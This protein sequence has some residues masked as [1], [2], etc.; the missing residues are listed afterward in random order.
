MAVSGSAVS[1]SNGNFKKEIAGFHAAYKAWFENRMAGKVRL[2]KGEHVC[3][4]FAHV[5]DIIRKYKH[6]PNRANN[7][8]N[9]YVSF[10][11]L[12]SSQERAALLS[13]HLKKFNYWTTKEWP[14]KHSY[15]P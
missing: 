14:P 8:K 1:G 5:P 15:T 3:D 4:N 6:L 9:D 7:M 11:V 2:P 10:L 12:T 13:K